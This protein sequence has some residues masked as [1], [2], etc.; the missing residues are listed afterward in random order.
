MTNQE[1]AGADILQQLPD[2]LLAELNLANKR[3]SQP[4]SP[5]DV[6]S[7]IRLVA[8]RG[9]GSCVLIQPGDSGYAWSDRTIPLVLLVRTAAGIRIRV[10]RGKSYRNSAATPASWPE[11]RGF[12]KSYVGGKLSK[13]AD[14]P[15]GVTIEINEARKLPA[16][17]ITCHV[18]EWNFPL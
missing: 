6:A 4:I 12:P 8:D 17:P 16:F 14:A 15:D 1:T 2:D 13:W 9:I 7:A 18:S 10:R 5:V 3:L 11:L